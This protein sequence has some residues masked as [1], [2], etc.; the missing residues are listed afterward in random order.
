MDSLAGEIT[1]IV[2]EYT[3][4]SAVLF[5]SCAMVSFGFSVR[6]DKCLVVVLMSRFIIF[7]SLY[8]LVHARFLVW[9]TYAI[10][11]EIQHSGI[12][13]AQGSGCHVQDPKNVLA[14]ACAVVMLLRS[15]DCCLSHLN[16]DR[17]VYQDTKL[18]SR[19]SAVPEV[20]LDPEKFSICSDSIIR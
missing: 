11:R 1:S 17:V 16:D 5:L 9:N 3:F 15:T 12:V 18:S 13:F 10:E 20:E 14:V 4:A 2:I 6:S 7:S 8:D 19:Y